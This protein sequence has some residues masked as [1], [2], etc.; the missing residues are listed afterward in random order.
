MAQ[1]ELTEE[2]KMLRTAVRDWAEKELPEGIQARD[3]IGDYVKAG[4]PEI[5]R[6]LAE[7]GFLAPDFPAEYGGSEMGMLSEIIV[8]EELA[9]VEATTGL[10]PADN[11]LGSLPII[12]TH[13][14]KAV[15]DKYLPRLCS[16]EWT[17]AHGLTET[18]GGSDVAGFTT[19]A[20]RKGDEY[21]INGNKIFITMGGVWPLT[22]L[23]CITDP[24]KGAYRGSSMIA[25]EWGTKGF[26]AGKHENKMGVRWSDT[27]E[28][29]FDNCHVPAENLCGQEGQGWAIEMMTLDLTRPAVAAMSQGIGQ[30]A[31]DYAL[32]YAKERIVFGKPILNH[33]ALAFKLV[34]MLIEIEASRELLYKACCVI[35]QY[36]K[37][38]TKRLPPEAVRYSSMCK[39]FTTDMGMRVSTEA[40]QVVGGYGFCKDYP[41]E[42]RM[43][44]NKIQQIWEGTNEINRIVV[45]GT[46][47]AK[48]L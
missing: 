4:G 24:E 28:L 7:Q 46:I 9:R 29:I 44:D 37:D 5:V 14:N 31:F 27:S 23:Y 10:M 16:G 21:I 30:G 26:T 17:C 43:R 40:V 34:D 47:G 35:G 3:E 15:R 11:A 1:Y 41:V 48:G 20:E 19:R 38:V 8:I 42:I 32:G 2:Q 36:P 33:E 13:D 45:A 22:C 6:K 12:L 18:S 25:V 39:I